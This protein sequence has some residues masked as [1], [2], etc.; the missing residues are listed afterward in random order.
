MTLSRRELLPLWSGF[1]LLFAAANAVSAVHTDPAVEPATAAAPQPA[2]CPS[3][4]LTRDCRGQDFDYFV[5]G[6]PAATRPG[7]TR[8][9]LVL[10]GGGGY[11]D[12]AYEELAQRAGRGHIVVLRAT[13][14]HS[15]DPEDGK[16]GPLFLGKWGQT[17][18]CQTF[19]FHSR[20]AAFDSRVIAALTNADGVFLAGG[21]QANYVH[22]WKGTPVQ[23]ALNDLVKRN[24]PIGGNSAGLAVL[25]HYSYIDVDGGSLES[26][27]ALADPLGR[28]VGLES[29]FL[30][31]QGLENAITDTHF[32][33][34]SRLGRLIVFVT[35][36]N[37]GSS[38]SRV[39]GIG[40]DERTAVL[41]DADGIGHVVAG[42]EGSAWV[43]TLDGAKWVVAQGKPLSAQNVVIKQLTQ[44]GVFH[45]K[46]GGV[47][48]PASVK[49][50][51]LESTTVVA[52]EP[53]KSMMLRYQ[54]PAGED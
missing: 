17:V 14:D 12:A 33:A 19:T 21:D 23:R 51:S 25:G 31:F 4:V 30:H 44:T 6:N 54:V 20:A 16:L 2:P 34:R 3:G 27:D 5:S 28:A 50:V 24:G 15:F 9:G 39:Y 18:S 38:S 37:N 36:L 47:D 48:K 43:V 52:D 11:I 46:D 8:F 49:R 41:I 42:S 10:M 32:S 29:D 1:V 13:D 7:K 26:K 22:Y 45:A 40:V 35:R 53:L